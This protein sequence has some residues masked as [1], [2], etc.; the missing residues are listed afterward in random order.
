VAAF[1]QALD[2]SLDLAQLAAARLRV[3]PAIDVLHD[4]DLSIVAFRAAAGDAATQRVFASINASGQLRVSSTTLH[5]RTAIR[6]AFLHP[7]TGEAQIEVV[8]Q[9]VRRALG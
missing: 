7:R 6:L 4:P 8:E 3:D 9:S 1:R 2:R 5:D